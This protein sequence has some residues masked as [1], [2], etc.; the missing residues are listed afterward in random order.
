MGNKLLRF[1]KNSSPYVAGDIAGVS[2]SE[3]KRY[4]ALE[5]AVEHHENR[6][7]KKIDIREFPSQDR[8]IKEENI[9][10]KTGRKIIGR[11]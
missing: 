1:V 6:I 7:E 8:M 11:K 2:A 4:L 10:V 5:V 9:I 3:A